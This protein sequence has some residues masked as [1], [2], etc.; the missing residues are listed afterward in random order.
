MT[1]RRQSLALVL[2]TMLTT[3]CAGATLATDARA[4]TP[5]PTPQVSPVHERGPETGANEKEPKTGLPE[6]G[7]GRAM[8]AVKG[9]GDEGGTA[10]GMPGKGPTAK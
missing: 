1:M 6:V 8:G 2:G 10:A 9:S 7:V 3:C 4:E 5:A